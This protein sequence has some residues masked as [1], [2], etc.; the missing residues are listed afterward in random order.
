MT[1]DLAWE[2]VL[3]VPGFA[4]TPEVRAAGWPD[5]FA[6]GHIACLQYPVEGTDADKSKARR[7]RSALCA[8]IGH[9]IEAGDLEAEQHSRTV[10]VRDDSDLFRPIVRSQYLSPRE[11]Y[12]RVR[13]ERR[14]ARPARQKVE[15]W[16]TVTRA[17]FRDWL[18]RQGEEP[19]VHIRAWLRPMEHAEACQE[20]AAP[21]KAKLKRD[22][23]AEVVERIRAFHAENGKLFDSNCMP[24]DAGDLLWLM[25][26]RHPDQFEEMELKAFREHYRAICKWPRAAGQQAGARSLYLEIFPEAKAPLAAVASLFK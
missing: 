22:F 26:R 16:Y 11:W 7:N 5:A 3:R 21:N 13:P 18:A 19:S 15:T 8:A 17:A 10:E 20:D 24:G 4:V 14:P 1:V 9:A 23:V 2:K 12:E 6:V 25:K